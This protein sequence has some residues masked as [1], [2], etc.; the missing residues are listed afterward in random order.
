M[1]MPFAIGRHLRQMVSE[2]LYPT[3]LQ[4]D[5][6]YRLAG[7]RGEPGR[8]GLGPL[9][10]GVDVRKLL[11][12]LYGLSTGAESGLVFVEAPNGRSMDLA[13]LPDGE[14]YLLLITDSTV[15]RDRQQEIQQQ[16]NEIALLNRRQGK[17]LAALEQANQVKGRFIAAMS[18]EFR[19]PLAAIKGQVE[20]LREQNAAPATALGVIDANAIHLLSLI[21]NVL[22]QAK[23]ES[24]QLQLTPFPNDPR[25]L[26][27]DIRTMFEPI[28]G[29]KGIELET[30]V[31]ADCPALLQLDAMRLRQVLVNLLGNA[32]KFTRE[33]RV[34]LRLKWYE[35]RLQGVVRDTGPG[36]PEAAQRRIFQA[37][38]QEKDTADDNATGAGLGLA[39]S[40]ELVSLMGGALRVKSQPGQGTEF[41]FAIEAPVSE[42][43][44]EHD[45]AGIRV[46]L[47]D[48][49]HDLRILLQHQLKKAGFQVQTVE[50]AAQVLEAVADRPPDVLL[51]DL[52]LGNDSG[53]QLARRL[54]AD[55]YSGG[56]LILSAASGRE[57]RSEALEAGCDD[58]MVKP[59][60]TQQLR[61]RLMELAGRGRVSG[62]LGD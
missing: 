49:S 24:G 36:I 17:L 12:C 20:L 18:H 61:R 29:R 35:G 47:A 30:D 13:L 46:L 5:R 52:Y 34:S 50:S 48:D 21:D 3:L 6:D 2:R 58:Y 14:G 27:R 42:R 8:F 31:A 43:I 19:T 11:P 28:A 32:F 7:W 41:S 38:H 56:I 10:S 57:E 39:I 60:P 37:F 40:S 45:P 15:E 22:D 26:L 25:E 55:G 9:E 59:V 4:L 16:A 62:Y 33:G 53:S 23:I 44:E 1:S 54:R 51:L